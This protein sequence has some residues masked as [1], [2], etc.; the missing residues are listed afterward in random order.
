[1]I[2]SAGIVPVPDAVLLLTMRWA[3]ARIH[4]E[5]DAARRPSTVHKID[6]VA[7][8]VGESREVLVCREPL[9]LEA[10]H[11]ARR[12]RA[13]MSRLA[14]D[15]PAHCRIAAQALGV[16]HVFVSGKATKYRLP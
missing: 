1:M 8:Q 5:H 15:D 6:P 14:A 7:G 12:G 16:V 3:H 4:V 9:R 13:T 2:A 11:L 10:A